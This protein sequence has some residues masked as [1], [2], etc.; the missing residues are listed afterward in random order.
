MDTRF[1]GPSG[2]RLLHCAT[3]LYTPERHDDYQAFFETIPYI[4]P[5]KYC[6][7]SLTEHY[8]QDP[9]NL[10]SRATLSHWFYRIHNRVN[11]AL[12]S[13]HLHTCATNPPFSQVKS[14]YYTWL[15][16]GP[17]SR[18]STF[19]DFLFSVAYNHPKGVER[20]T[21]PIEGCPAYAMNCASPTTRNR[22][23]TLSTEDRLQ[24]YTRFWDTLPAVL[25]PDLEADWRSAHQ[26]R[27]LSTRRSTLA[28]LWR[29]R[30]AIDNEFHDPYQS[31]CRYVASYSS[32]CGSSSGR[33]KTCR[34][35]KRV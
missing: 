35:R 24:W 26:R 16:K 28:W 5:C 7:A 32:D 8:E 10:T 33:R 12:R 34:R 11:D 2:W 6:R 23:N 20:T 15:N 18:L 30:C 27:D 14:Q 25:G 4:L 21:K 19:W 9:M 31:V 13:K 17:L 1:W 29:Q 22:W 3:F